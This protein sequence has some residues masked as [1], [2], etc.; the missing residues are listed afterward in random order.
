MLPSK[1][2]TLMF[3]VGKVN[4]ARRE[5]NKQ[6]L[7]KPHTPGLHAAFVLPWSWRKGVIWHHTSNRAASVCATARLHLEPFLLIS[8]RKYLDFKPKST[9]G[10][11]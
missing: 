10:D 7:I 1:L 9:T 8:R 6:R 4:S 3:L 2:I 5:V 11:W